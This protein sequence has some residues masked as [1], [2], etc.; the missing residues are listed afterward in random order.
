MLSALQEGHWPGLGHTPGRVAWLCHSLGLPLERCGVCPIAV[1][2]KHCLTISGDYTAAP[3]GQ[4]RQRW[5]GGLMMVI[6][7]YQDFGLCWSLL[8]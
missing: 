4:S 2:M 7:L 6:L 8:N 3:L 5:A 1:I